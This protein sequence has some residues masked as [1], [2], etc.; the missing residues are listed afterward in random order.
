MKVLV[1]GQGGREHA[2][3]HALS[4]SS[5][6][7]EIHVI[8]GSDGMMSQALCHKLDWK[9]TEAL[10]DFC[11]KTEIEY[12]VIGPEDP[13]VAGLADRLRERGILCVG[14]S[15]EG[16]KLE[17]SKIFAKE[18]M[19]QAKIPT[20]KYEVVSYVEETLKKCEHF[21]PPYVFKADGLAAGK[22]VYIC[23]D[24]EDLERSA[25]EVFEKKI[26]GDAGRRAI[27]EQFSPGWELSY[28]ILTNGNDF[29]T[30]PL[31]Q[32]HKRLCDHDEGPNTG[33][34]GTIAPLKIS[35]NLR[36]DIDQKIVR[37]TLDNLKKNGILYRGVI[38]FGLM[39]TEQ[40]PSLLEYNCR[41]GDPET[42]VI[43]PLVDGDWGQILKDLAAG[44][45]KPI[46]TK[47]MAATC[48]VMAAPGYPYSPQKGV[49]IE[50]DL[51]FSS[52]SGYFLHAGT[53][54]ADANNWVTNGGRVLCSMG[55]GPTLEEAQKAAYVQ[56]SKVTWNR[57]QMRKDIGAKMIKPNPTKTNAN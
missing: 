20:A 44:I 3:V 28:L 36:D 55:I 26:L 12:V 52:P 53:A 21:T 45:L 6:V 17:G 10:I 8:P 7:T 42:Q 35:Q 24:K 27:L 37:P 13:L 22:G 11:L 4:Q 1:L 54:K 41:F 50:G 33:G 16:A 46:Q 38:F 48:V 9:S 47:N 15:Q 29:Q 32:D 2:L 25:R 23:K 19:T 30:L 43:L 18:F 14:P 51:Q 57:I 40:G 56:A 49:K 39:I 31:A 5:L 34:M